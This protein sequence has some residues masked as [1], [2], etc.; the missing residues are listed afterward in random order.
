MPNFL[1]AALLLSIYLVALGG[2]TA[3]WTNAGIFVAGLMM[4][5]RIALLTNN[6]VAI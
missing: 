3:Q 5:L 4:V 1:E 2:P 6:A